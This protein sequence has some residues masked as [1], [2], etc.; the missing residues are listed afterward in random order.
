MKKL[1]FILLSLSIQLVHSQKKEDKITIKFNEILKIDVLKQI[2]SKTNYTFYF[3]EEWLDDKPVSGVYS[4]ISLRVILNDIFNDTV[5]NFYISEDNKIILTLN[6]LIYDSLPKGFFNLNKEDDIV[7]DSPNP[8]FYAVKASTKKS[9]VETIRIGK[10]NK[11]LK[12]K[13]YSLSGYVKNNVTGEPIPNLVLSVPDKNINAVS[14]IDG[15]YS[16]K[17]PSGINNIE[18]KSLGI[19]N[20]KKRII[21]YSDGV[22]NFKLAENLELLDEVIIDADKDKNVKEA[23]TGI[24]QIQVKDIKNIPL[25]LGERDVLKVATTLPGISTA[26]EGT[27]GFNVRGGNADQ[28]LMLLDNAVIYNPTHFFGIFSALN[29]YT[30]GDLNIYKGSIPAEYGGRLSSVFEINTKIGNKEKFSGEG[31]VGPVTS[32]LTLE[33]PVV[34]EKASLIIGGRATYSDWILKRLDEESLQ[35][36]EASFYDIIAKYNHQINEKNNIET[37]GYYSKDVFSVSSDSTFSYSNTL[38]SLKWNHI[39]NEKNRGS[40]IIAN[41]NYDFNIEFDSNANRNFDLNYK[42]QETEAKLIMNYKL[43]DQH[44]FNYGLSSKLYNNTPGNITPI[45]SESI[46]TPTNIQGE[47]ALESAIFISDNFDVSENF[48]VSLGFR[49]S[50]YAFLG[51][52]TQNIYIDGLPKNDAT[53]TDTKSYGNNEVVETY[54]GPEVRVSARYS[55][56]PSFSVK[57]SYN[58]NYQFIHSLTT[59]TTATPMDTWKLSDSNIKPQQAKQFS[60]GLFK[61]IDGNVYELSLEGYYKLSDNILDY[62]VGSDL[63]LNERIETEVLQGEGKA[64]GVELLIKKNKGKLNGWIGYTYSR[65]LIK[66]DSEFDVERVN[67]GDFFPSNFDKPHDFSIVAN[68]KLTKRYSF[69]MNFIYQTGR[70]VTFP[71]GNYVFN[72]SQYVFYSNRNEFRIPDYYRLD[73]GINIEGNH[74][75]KKLAHSFWNISVYNVLGRNN[76]FS[77]FFVTENGE[78]KAYQSSI[79]AVPVPTITYNF[80]F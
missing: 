9:S 57:A 77:V 44:S 18:I 48:S 34:Q 80:R 13:T 26:G 66:L 2:E 43:N 55:F 23:I 70:P 21:I 40:L 24:T 61:N 51:E 52:T 50:F 29:P 37:T 19:E 62:K 5:I 15:F 8:V 46:V 53:L 72:N 47:K 75:I 49:Y 78:I 45:G 20:L 54:G 10:E 32:N 64:Y 60:L 28:N 71:V 69:S 3:V 38:F 63:L 30:T 76:P 4:N 59:N 35:N 42:V 74:K 65:S 73:L 1:L 17:I 58:N 12:K 16:I 68:Y 7:K 14:D 31:A 11:S 79:F 25:V 22:Y 67:N 33:I 39:F 36:S 56:T 41:S 27:S 6:N